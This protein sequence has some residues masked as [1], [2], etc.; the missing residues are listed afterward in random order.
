ME[1]YLHLQDFYDVSI[2]L[3]AITML[4]YSTWIKSYLR[5]PCKVLTLGLTLLKLVVWQLDCSR[6]LDADDEPFAYVFFVKGGAPAHIS[7]ITSLCNLGVGA[8]NYRTDLGKV[9]KR[10]LC[11][12][13]ILQVIWPRWKMVLSVT[14]SNYIEILWWARNVYTVWQAECLLNYIENGHD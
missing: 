5:W 11:P 14:I 8:R 1:N 13:T 7:G 4:N 6:D 10:M 9:C 3:Q 2:L 12:S